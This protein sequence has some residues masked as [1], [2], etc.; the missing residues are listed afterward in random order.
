MGKPT[1]ATVR[2]EFRSGGGMK[3]FLRIT[4]VVALVASSLGNGGIKAY[5]DFYVK[6][7]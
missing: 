1:L 3:R 4:T 5:Q 7:Q 6:V 2:G